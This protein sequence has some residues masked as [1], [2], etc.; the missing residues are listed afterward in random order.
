MKI[1]ATAPFTPAWNNM[2]RILFKPFD[3]KKWFV[4]GFCAFLAQCGEGGGGGNYANWNQSGSSSFRETVNGVEMW[5]ISNWELFL[6]LVSGCFLL[7]LIIN[8][9]VIWLSSRGKFMLIDGIVKNRAAVS[10][11]WNE[12]RTEGNSLFLLRFIVSVIS[13]ICVALLIGI[14]AYLAYPDFQAETWGEGSTNALVVFLGLG[15]PFVIASIVFAFFLGGFVVPI[16][17]LCRVRVLEGMKLAWEDIWKE[18]LG[19]A[20]LLFLMMILFGIGIGIIAVAVTCA[21]CCI[22][23]LPYIGSV[24]FLPITVFLVCYFLLYIEQF[25]KEWRFFK[26]VCV[27]CGYD[28]QGLPEDSQCPECGK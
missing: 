23:A 17:Y 8:L 19:S 22:A 13:L 20:F 9:L 15:I 18:H 6:G 7:I 3:I 11:P 5:I 28:L 26:E 25:G 27:S 4:L 2:V 24:I 1:S 10:E 16:M 21:T 14:P 12:Y